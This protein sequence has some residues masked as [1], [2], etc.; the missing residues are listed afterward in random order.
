MSEAPIQSIQ[1]SCAVLDQLAEAAARGEGVGLQV[2]AEALGVP[3]TTAHNLLKSLV[4]CGY[5]GRGEQRRYT[6]GPRALDLARAARLSAGGLAAAAAEAA[7]LAERTGESVVVTTLVHGRR[8]V[9]RRFEGSAV[10]R[11]NAAFDDQ[12]PLW[13]MV[14]GRVLAA[15]ATPAELQAVLALGPPSAAWPELHRASDLEPALAAIRAAGLAEAITG[16]QEVVSMA[17]PILDRQGQLLAALGLYLPA[18]RATS[19]ASAGLRA[20]LLATAARVTARL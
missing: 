5:A 16:Q 3:V 17:A 13:A 11:V 18:F 15:F 19:E 8:Q 1:R 10:V 7:E 9:L 20:E 4:A 14:T 2:V 6:L 12:A